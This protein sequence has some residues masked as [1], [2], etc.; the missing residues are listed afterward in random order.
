MPISQKVCLILLVTIEAWYAV[1]V[2]FYYDQ[3]DDIA[4]LY[5]GTGWRNLRVYLLA[6]SL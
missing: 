3:V 5:A 2:E 1:F 6:F 4:Y